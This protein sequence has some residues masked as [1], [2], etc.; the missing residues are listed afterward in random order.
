MKSALTKLIEVTDNNARKLGLLRT[1]VRQKMGLSKY[2]KTD[3][4]KLT[5]LLGALEHTNKIIE[6][7]GGIELNTTKVTDVN[8]NQAL[9]NALTRLQDQQRAI[10]PLL[11]QLREK[12]KA[13]KQKQQQEKIGEAM[14]L[15]RGEEVTENHTARIS[16][17]S[18]IDTIPVTT[19]FKFPADAEVVELASKHEKQSD[20]TA[21][22]DVEFDE[23][24]SESPAP[25]L[26]DVDEESRTALE[27]VDAFTQAMVHLK[28]Q[29]SDAA[30]TVKPLVSDFIEYINGLNDPDKVVN[31]K[32]IQ[33]LT[34]AMNQT[35]ALLAGG[36]IDEYINE[37]KNKMR[38]HASTPLKII[39]GLMLAIGLAVSGLLLAMTGVGAV[40][41]AAPTIAA[42][43]TIAAPTVL[44]LGVS[45]FCFFA[46]SQKVGSVSDRACKIADV[47]QKARL[48]EGD[49]VEPV[50]K[51]EMN[52]GMVCNF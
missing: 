5:L 23:D 28:A 30:P 43:A 4:E 49:V 38:G 29:L 26:N 13:L 35:A 16:T 1:H 11:T 40:V 24:S 52:G 6:E 45:S 33:D 48:S 51:P 19:N 50:Q 41:L 42:V 21:M 37:A 25:R 12:I 39:G 9:N 34:Q 46:S 8:N 18:D 7:V 20:I 10:A 44:G 27:E 17:R 36:D 3:E 32:E 15:S 31:D 22:S 47:Y 2:I 14:M